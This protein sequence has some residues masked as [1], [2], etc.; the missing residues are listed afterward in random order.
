MLNADKALSIILKAVKPL[1]AERIKLRNALGR[2]LGED[3]IAAED[4]PPFDNSSMDGFAV[5]AADL[6]GASPRKPVTL[7]VVGEARAGNPFGARLRS[8]Q[9][10]R[11]MT[12]GKI[13]AGTDSVVPVELVTMQD[14]HHVRLEHP[15][16][17]GA[18]IRR[19]GEDIR[20][21]TRVLKRGELLTP[22]RLGILA[23]LGYA[24]VQVVRQPRVN[25]LATGDEL[26][27]VRKK[28][29]D[30]QIR[31]SSTYVL[32]GYVRQ[33]GGKPRLLGIVGDK[34]RR[35]RRAIERGF[36][37]DILLITG[38][39]SVGKY[40]LVGEVVQ[41]L[42]VRIKF[43][44]VNIKP[45]KPLLFGTF[46]RT[47]V[48]GLPGNPVSTGVTFLQFVRPALAAMLGQTGHERLRLHAILDEP[49][50]KQDGKRHFVRGVAVVSNGALHVATTGSQS[51]G[52]V[53]S[54]GKANCLII[55][56]ENVRN[57]R[58]GSK[59]EV[60]FID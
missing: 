4:I 35:L 47:L 42:G 8:G 43:W 54:L 6:A 22:A 59:V 9:A 3:I 55:L 23:A 38:G 32:Q 52:M 30:G 13:P 15:V 26:V 5:A 1:D 53:S 33:A 10:V 37:G 39:V 40:D 20:K 25:I 2:T 57:V 51:S 49:L 19:A 18:N 27:P 31:N 29:R 45:G 16:K 56:P 21:K 7:T 14:E 36:D 44:R 11:I 28:P 48:F 34:K 41:K 60:E 12:G 58:K 24:K 17:R 46:G 50:T